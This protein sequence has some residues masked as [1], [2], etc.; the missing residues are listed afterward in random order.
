MKHHRRSAQV[1]RVFSSRDLTVLL[2]RIDLRGELNL[3]APVIQTR[4]DS[5]AAVSS[6]TRQHS[7]IVISYNCLVIVECLVILEILSI[8][9]FL[10]CSDTVGCVTEG[11]PAC[12]KVGVRI[13]MV[14]IWLELCT[15]C[16]SSCHHYLHHLTSCKIRNGDILVPANPGPPGK[17][18][19][20]QR[21]KVL[22]ISCCLNNSSCF[23]YVH[24]LSM[25]CD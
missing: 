20:Y 18:S 9:F 15:S 25:V 10:H 6:T 11:H 5:T 12:T 4:S 16:S 3:C 2:T 23:A 19:L 7:N 1:W 24:G 17:W 13:L 8:S 22:T 14:T 21:Q